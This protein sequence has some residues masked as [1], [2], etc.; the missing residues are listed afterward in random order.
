MAAADALIGTIANT[1][2]A[3]VLSDTAGNLV[4]L[5]AINGALVP[6][7]NGS[8]GVGGSV[9]QLT[10]RTT[11]VTLN[12]MTGT[13]TTNNA[14]LAGLASA[15]FIV[16]NSYVA[17][18]DVVVLSMQSGSNSGGS[19]ATVAIT[20]AGTFTIRVSNNNAA[21]GTAETGAILLNFAVIK[22]GGN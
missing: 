16:T 12:T 4:R 19:F 22:A 3:I 5:T 13:I 20:T 15:D 1:D 2:S 10:S 6:T 18:G 17:I 14:S 9:T 7:K 11:G 8:G 21:A